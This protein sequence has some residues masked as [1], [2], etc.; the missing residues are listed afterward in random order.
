[1]FSLVHQHVGCFHLGYSSWSYVYWLMQQLEQC[2]AQV[3]DM[4]LYERLSWTCETVGVTYW[5]TGHQLPACVKSIFLSHY[6]VVIQQWMLSAVLQVLLT[7]CLPLIWIT[8]RHCK[9]WVMSTAYN[10]D[11]HS[12]LCTLHNCFTCISWTELIIDNT[13]YPF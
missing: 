8:C 10:V 1:M 3:S 6:L 11:W 2:E 7:F 9:Y 5:M 4:V 13:S 12:P